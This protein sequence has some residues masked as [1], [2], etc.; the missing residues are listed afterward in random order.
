MNWNTQ[1]GEAIFL[2][3]QGWMQTGSEPLEAAT[4]NQERG[5]TML[6]L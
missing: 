3:Q 2:F 1:E 4:R 5:E 6:K